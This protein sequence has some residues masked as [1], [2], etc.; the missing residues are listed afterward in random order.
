M[1]IAVHARIKVSRADDAFGVITASTLQLHI[2]RSTSTQID[3]N[4][5]LIPNN[6]DFRQ[7]QIPIQ[8]LT[9]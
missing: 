5:Y 1:Q 9:I 6:P 3:T 2:I 4:T 7:N 8:S